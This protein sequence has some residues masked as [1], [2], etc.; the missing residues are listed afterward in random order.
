MRTF[1]LGIG[2][3]WF[4]K[5]RRSTVFEYR[6]NTSRIETNNITNRNFGALKQY[7]KEHP[8]I[9]LSVRQKCDNSI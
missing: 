1:V 5:K 4:E 7:E 3:Y 9:S 6:S 2:H 8:L